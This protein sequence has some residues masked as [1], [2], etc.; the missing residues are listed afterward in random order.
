ML[1]SKRRGKITPQM[2][3]DVQALVEGGAPL[4]TAVTK[5]S[6]ESGV[7]FTLN[8]AIGALKLNN[9]S[10]YS[11]MKSKGLLGKK[12]RSLR[13]QQT[14][15]QSLVVHPAVLAVQRGAT[16]QEAANKYSTEKKKISIQVLGKWVREVQAFTGRGPLKVRTRRTLQQLQDDGYY[17]PKP[18]QEQ[19]DAEHLKFISNHPAVLDV[20]NGLPASASSR[21]HADT[22]NH[23][24][25]ATLYRWVAKVKAAKLPPPEPSEL[26][27][28]ENQ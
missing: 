10:W 13:T 28:S 18:T 20:L 5:V 26:P 25:V 22:D 9:P 24:P 4:S 17:D 7:T 27:A 21:K 6:A 16:L 12:G 23:V 8:A 1:N 19:K 14:R 11:D 2:L 3:L 15:L